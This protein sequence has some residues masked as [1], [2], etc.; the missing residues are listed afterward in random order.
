MRHVKVLQPIKLVDR[1]TG[2]Q[3]AELD[4]DGAVRPLVISQTEYAIIYWLNDK[5]AA[6]TPVE[7]A[8]LVKLVNKFTDVAGLEW[9][10]LEDAEWERLRPIV[11]SP[12]ASRGPMAEIQL[13]PFTRA[14]L[15]APEGE[16][17]P[18]LES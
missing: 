9:I 17:P 11:E 13:L 2:K 8:K 5:R 16:T 14:F 18:K 6:S 3:M 7:Y 10:S 15:D 12:N 4:T 1:L